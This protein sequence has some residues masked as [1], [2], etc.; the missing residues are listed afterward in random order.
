MLHRFHM[1]SVGAPDVGVA[2]LCGSWSFI[3]WFG[4]LLTAGSA[5]LILLVWQERDGS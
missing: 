5:P 1:V 4:I 2:R 3:I